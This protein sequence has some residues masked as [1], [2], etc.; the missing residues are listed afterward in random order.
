MLGLF[1]SLAVLGLWHQLLVE[2]QLHLQKLVRREAEAL[3]VELNRELSS[4]ILALERM[5]NRWQAGGG[6]AETLWRADAI[7]YVKYYGYQAIE[8]VDPSFQVHWVVPQQGNEVAQNLNLGREPR[9]QLTLSIA[10]DLNQ[11]LLTRTLSLAQGG[12]GF[13]AAVPLYL[14]VPGSVPA[15]DRFDGFLVG[16]FR[17]QTLFD[18]ILHVSPRYRVQIY[19]RGQLIYSQG[20]PSTAMQ[21]QIGVVQAYGADWQVQVFP[22]PQL[23]GEE[24]SLLP[25]VVLGGGLA[26]VWA[27]ALLV[28]L[29]Q[30][31]ARQTQRV[32]EINQHLQAEIAQRQQI[33]IE[34]RQSEAFN[35]NLSE[36]LELA[37]QSAQIGIWDWDIVNDRLIWSER[38]YQLYGVEPATCL[39]KHR[40]WKK[41]LHPDDVEKVTAALE[42]ALHGER[43]FDPE[44]RVV[45]PDGQVRFIKAHAIV[46]RDPQ[47]KPLRM[48]G[49]NFDI[50]ERK[51]AEVAL[52][53][54]ESTLRSF[55]DSAAMMMGVVALYEQDILHISDNQTTATF[56]GLT[57]ETM[58]DRFASELGVPPAHLQ[59]WINFYREAERAQAPIRFEYW[60]E[61]SDGQ[62][63]L[64]ASVCPIPDRSSPYPRFSYIV[65]DITERKQAETATARLAAIVGSSQDAIIGTSLEGTITS[66]NAGAEKIFG[67]TADEMV[68]QPVTQLIPES[69]LEEDRQV[70]QRIRCGE[71]VKNYD[72]KRRRKDGSLVDLSISLS[73]VV[74]YQGN[75]IGAAKIARDISDKVRL[76]AERKRAEQF[77]QQSEAKYRRI[78]QTA[79]EGIWMIDAENLTSFVNPRMADLLGYG[80]AEMIG[81]PLSA[82]MTE[83]NWLFAQDQLRNRRQGVSEHHEFQ[84]QRKDGTPLCGLVSANPITDE[85]GHYAGAVAMVTDIT[86]RKAAE[87]K[88]RK[89]EAALAEAQRMVHLGNWELDIATRK[90]TWS[91]ELFR[92]FGFDPHN[93]EPAYAEH[94]NYIHPDDRQLLQQRLERAMSEGIPYE[95][96]LRWLK[97]DGSIGYMEARGEA[98]YNPQGQ[99]EKLFGTALDITERKVAELALAAS[100]QRYQNL[101]ENS[102]DIIERFDL[103]LRHLYVSPIL[104]KITGLPPEA[105]SGKTCRE[106]GMDEA[107]V[108]TWESAAAKLLK[109]GQKQVIE[110]EA[111]TLEGSRSFEMAIAPELSTEGMIESILCI[112]RDITERKQTEAALRQSEE[113]FRTA[114]DYTYNWEYWQA[115]DG[116]FVYIS[117]SCERVTGYPTAAFIKNP[118]LLQEIIHPDDREIF[119]HHYCHDAASPEFIDYRIITQSGEIRWISHICQ[120]L[121]NSNGQFLGIRASNRDI[122]ARRQAEE[123]LR[124]INLVMQNA[125][126]GISQLDQTG[127][128][129]GVNRAYAQ[130]CGYEPD[131]LIGQVWTI[132]VY[133][134]DLAQLEAAYQTMLETGKVEVEARGMRKDGSLFYK[135]VTM[136]A[137]YDDR[138]NLLG[139]HCFMKDIS[140][141]KAIENQLRHLNLELEE[142]V[143]ERTAALM[144]SETMFRQL[145]EHI[146]EVFF[147]KSADLEQ[148]LYISPAYETVWGR[149]C[150][151]LYRQPQS[152]L[153]TIHPQDRDRILANLGKSTAG[154]SFSEEYRIIRPDGALRWIYERTSPIFNPTSQLIRH[155]GIAEDITE[156]KQAE[157]SLQAS[158]QEKV[159]LLREIHH[160]VKNNLQ[161]VSSLLELQAGKTSDP[162]ACSVLQESQER[163][164]AIALVH[165]HLYKSPNLSQVNF[166]DYA[167]SLVE[168]VF[169]T[170]GRPNLKLHLALEPMIINLET[171]FPCGLLLNEL[172]SNALKH[173]FPDQQAGD[174]WVEFKQV[175]EGLIL[176]VKDNGIGFPAHLDFRQTESLGLQLVTDLSRQLNGTLSLHNLEEH[177]GFRQGTCFQLE[178][179]ELIY[180]KRL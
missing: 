67:Y 130:T 174:I 38:M 54:S 59:Q 50:T 84:F 97:T 135:Q 153:D 91:D 77:L 142:R 29:G 122:T 42:L 98:K 120:P 2:E 45:H 12:K 49:V 132:T 138:G 34:L 179:H 61:T 103:Q 144:Q 92:M 14:K 15:T 166:S 43:L 173:A 32:R 114:I 60:H 172:V 55:F 39:G 154:G 106:L 81:Q 105:F 133:P 22:T 28:Y 127:R 18:S 63:C 151:S 124:H 7:N 94:F 21:P 176:V 159:L 9:R 102:P 6:T 89:N 85:A 31:S 139:H 66:W 37:V 53:Q 169:L 20:K 82:F 23:L 48:I 129:V 99:I 100:Q 145:S 5:G 119:A 74:D 134:D 16:V 147:V 168:Q 73:P 125:V 163:I 117:P 109:T 1:A 56:F 87:E 155:V 178:F 158:L 104:T 41:S 93:P 44:F 175:G 146:N 10:R 88:L 137:D 13:F 157:I 96:E 118:D 110:F 17:I 90:I 180:S 170:W 69:Y 47:S 143:Q 160:R 95:I 152:W 72:T 86:D 116:N 161:I 131:D 107:M 113:K 121:F 52:Q 111:L 30:R 26:G 75:L 164:Y 36:R 58:Q 27:L 148:I 46:Q 24:R 140:D 35:R 51:Q 83:D 25:T 62:H 123:A 156:R 108:N 101:V 3:E 70:L 79:Y 165:E 115:P 162:Y 141:R 4:R 126:E 128:Y 136:I 167:Q 78:I 149:T 177:R 65:E 112:S 76:D 80:V 150:E 64:A 68:G 8:W 40:I 57:P 71:R 171:A 11:T 19:D 33:E